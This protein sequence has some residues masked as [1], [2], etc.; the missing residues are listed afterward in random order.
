MSFANIKREER[1]GWR[2]SYGNSVEEITRVFFVCDCGWEFQCGTFMD[3][4]QET[5]IALLQHRLDHIEG[6]IEIL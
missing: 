5:D 3:S 1:Q 2:N 6:K 4:Q